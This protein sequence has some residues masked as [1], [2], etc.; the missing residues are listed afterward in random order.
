MLPTG[1]IEIPL[2]LKTRENIKIDFTH[3]HVVQIQDVVEEVI[4]S[5]SIHGLHIGICVRPGKALF[6]YDCIYWLQ[7]R[8]VR[9][10]HRLTFLKKTFAVVVKNYYLTL[11]LWLRK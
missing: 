11:S 1:H 10:E 5:R 9:I 3:F 6:T 7:L 8:F 2:D 4:E